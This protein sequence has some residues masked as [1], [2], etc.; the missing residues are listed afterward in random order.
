MLAIGTLQT[1]ANMTWCSLWYAFALW[2]A[3][4]QPDCHSNRGHTVGQKA[5]GVEGFL[6]K[7]LAWLGS[8]SSLQ[9]YI[10]SSVAGSFGICLTSQLL[11]SGAFKKGRCKPVTQN[12]WYLPKFACFFWKVDKVEACCWW[13]KKLK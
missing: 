2:D 7:K 11:H 9:W 4:A 13:F 6:F 12:L 10:W 3:G 5:S 8:E 1:K